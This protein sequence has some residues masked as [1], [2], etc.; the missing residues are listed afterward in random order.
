MCI[1]IRKSEKNKTNNNYTRRERQ[2]KT[3]RVIN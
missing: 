3:R 1:T 2:K